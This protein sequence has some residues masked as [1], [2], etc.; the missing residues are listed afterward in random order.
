MLTVILND[1]IPPG[2]RTLTAT[3]EMDGHSAV[4]TTAF[5]YGTSLPDLRPGA[6]WVAAGGTVTRTV[7]ALVSNH[8]PSTAAATTVYFYDGDPALGG[9]LIGSAGIPSLEAAG[10]ATVA[11]AWDV[12]GEG[13]EHA[14]HVVVDPVTEYDTGNNGAQAIVTLP[15]L[16]TALTVA[17][18]HIEPGS[19]VALGVQLENL[20][21][22]ADLPVTVTLKIR[23]PLGSLV[24]EQLWTETLAGSEVRWLN[25][26]WPSEEGAV[27]GTYSVVQEA[28]DA[29]GECYQNRSSFIIGP[30]DTR[31][32]YLPLVLRGFAP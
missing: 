11:V 19:P 14:L 30:L 29:H 13:G 32:I 28:C 15:R 21:A 22:A 26:A 2:R 10:Q 7:G 5:A 27:L 3:L 4:A 18:S 20:Q 16:D 1:P 12:V 24:Y 9:D 17:P 25:T 6:P 31:F 8:G 23:T